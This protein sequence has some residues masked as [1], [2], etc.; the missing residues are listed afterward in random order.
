MDTDANEPS[1]RLQCQG[2]VDPLGVQAIR[3]ILAN[4]ICQTAAYHEATSSTNTWA[5]NES[6][7]ADSLPRLVVADSQTAGRGRLGR[8]WHSD[9]GTLTFS[10]RVSATALNLSS[11]VSPMI[12]LAAGMGVADAIEH[13]LAPLR[14]Q[15]K[16]PN[17][18]YLGNRKI[19]GILVEATGPKAER[20]VV[21]VGINIDT[22]FEQAAEPLSATATSLSEA[23]TTGLTRYELLPSVV[24]QIVARINQLN[25]QTSEFLD[26]Y[27]TRCYLTGKTI[28]IERPDRIFTGTVQGVATDGGLTVVTPTGPETIYSG[29]IEILAA[30]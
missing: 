21:G 22:R 28:R 20:V 27:R 19:A 11:A 2:T 9:Q 24:Q 16:W 15:L 13:R 23:A 3:Q 4:G 10:L 26:E 7:E 1:S 12:A 17:D 29:V 5:L 18:V 25:Q 30:K 6:V 8:N 14:V